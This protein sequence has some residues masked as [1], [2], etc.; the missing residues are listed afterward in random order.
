[1]EREIL[2]PHPISEKAKA[3]IAAMTP[4]QKKLHDLALVALGSSYFVEQSRGY[5]AFASGK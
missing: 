5:L 3:Y 1:M 4:A 2:P